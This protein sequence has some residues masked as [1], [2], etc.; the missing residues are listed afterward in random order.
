MVE[1]AFS[2]ICLNR[3]EDK[4]P[5]VAPAENAVF[6]HVYDLDSVT[7]KINVVTRHMAQSGVFHVGVQVYNDEW[8]FGQHDDYVTGVTCTKP[9]GHLFHVYR[10]S[11]YMGETDLSRAEVWLL[12]ERLK[13]EWP[14][15]SY[16]LFQRNCITFA[17]VL[18]H[19]LGVKRVPEWVWRLP[20]HAAGLGESIKS[21]M[22]TLNELDETVGFS[23]GVKAI[24]DGWEKGKKG[25]RRM[26]DPNMAV[27]EQ[28]NQA[29]GA[30]TGGSA[31]SRQAAGG[32]GKHDDEEELW[33][34]AVGSGWDDAV[35]PLGS[36]PE[37]ERGGGSTRNNYLHKGYRPPNAD[38]SGPGGGGPGG[39]RSLPKPVFGGS[40]GSGRKVGPPPGAAG[41]P[42]RSSAA[43][44]DATEG[45]G[46]SGTT[47]GRKSSE[48]EFL[49]R[50]SKS[51]GS[52]P[53][54][55]TTQSGGTP[56][57]SRIERSLQKSSNP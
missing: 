38:L 18:C 22:Q 11:V 42:P 32:A 20:R 3:D 35:P 26:T 2:C 1:E 36:S 6:L 19:E 49:E 39:L 46:A 52:I 9:K 41:T 12:L 53:I 31:F 50:M 24:Q 7:A 34:K 45:G 57:S 47:P 51:S 56:M 14:G 15:N 44:K 43:G 28:E 8:C 55:A 27:E 54:G 25:L 17:D 30:G 5:E 23:E 48:T 21:G 13:P 4:L 33:V 40:A 10:E 37:R 29:P 16:H